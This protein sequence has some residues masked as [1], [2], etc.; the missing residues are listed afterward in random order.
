MMAQATSDST[1]NLNRS[2]IVDSARVYVADFK[3]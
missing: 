1:L 3:R 2:V